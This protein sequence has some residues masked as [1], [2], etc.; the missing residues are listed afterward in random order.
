MA[1]SVS[2]VIADQP[3]ENV[4]R[5]KVV[6]KKITFDNT[7]YATG[8]FTVT[9]A[10]LG[11]NKIL[12]VHA[13]PATD[14]GATTAYVMRFN[15]TSGKIQAFTSNGAAPAALAELPNAST[16][17]NGFVTHLRVVGY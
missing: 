16:A 9:A 7:A 3:A 13:T 2:N 8:G 12:D 4:G 6:Y 10:S 1:H 15:H 5:E 14:S 11:L 17:L